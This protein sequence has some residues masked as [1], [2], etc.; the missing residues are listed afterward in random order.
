MSQNFLTPITLTVRLKN[1]LKRYKNVIYNED[2]NLTFI[3]NNQKLS[4][5]LL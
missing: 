3:K 2:D 1:I 4:P 5:D